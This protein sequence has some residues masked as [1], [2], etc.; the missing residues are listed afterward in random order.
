MHNINHTHRAPT[1]EYSRVDS[2]LICNTVHV[3]LYSTD[4]QSLRA[5][6]FIDLRHH[7]ELQAG[8]A[9]SWL[10]P[11]YSYQTRSSYPKR[12]YS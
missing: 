5:Y 2:I 12:D 3:A 1:D 10:F 7:G 6:S 9:A 11:K 4:T 8:A